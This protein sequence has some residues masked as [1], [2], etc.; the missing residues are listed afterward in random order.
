MV[1]LVSTRAPA[2]RSGPPSN[3]YSNPVLVPSSARSRA[4]VKF[5]SLRVTA[6]CWSRPAPGP[7]LVPGQDCRRRCPTGH[8]VNRACVTQ[9]EVRPAFNLEACQSVHHS[10]GFDRDWQAGAAGPG[11]LRR[12]GESPTRVAGAGHWHRDTFT[13]Q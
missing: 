11:T 5:W 6:R 9:L 8:Q 13:C 12:T 4:E 1:S 2:A 7:G 10:P 3:L